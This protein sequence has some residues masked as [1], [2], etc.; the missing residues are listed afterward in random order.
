MFCYVSEVKPGRMVGSVNIPF[1]NMLDSKAKVL[2]SAEE[3]KQEFE[4]VE[5]DLNKPIVAS[6]GSGKCMLITY[7]Y[8]MT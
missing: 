6:C 7:G 3:I 2:K 8:Y 4:K 5:I 1:A